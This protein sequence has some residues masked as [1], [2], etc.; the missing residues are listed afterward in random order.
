MMANPTLPLTSIKQLK[1]FFLQSGSVH[2]SLRFSVH[3]DWFVDL[4]EKHS[5]HSLQFMRLSEIDL[6]MGFAQWQ[7][8][9][10]SSR[11]QKIYLSMTQMYF[12]FQLTISTNLF[13]GRYLISP[14]LPSIL[15]SC[16][17]FPH[18]EPKRYGFPPRIQEITNSLCSTDIF[19]RQNIY[20]RLT[21]HWSSL[22]R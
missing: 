20:G 4:V 2:E 19:Q 1:W 7:L 16:Q 3:Q 10:P 15:I 8:W 9:H 14:P 21:H 18:S 12:L 5:N 13:L 6:E 17:M 22:L 11:T